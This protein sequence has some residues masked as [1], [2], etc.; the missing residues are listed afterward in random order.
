MTT[1]DET[2]TSAEFSRLT[3]LLSRQLKLFERLGALSEHQT[4]FVDTGQ[5][6]ALLALLA[7]RQR[8]VDR[9]ERI[10]RDL[11]PFRSQWDTVWHRLDASKRQTVGSLI[12]QVQQ[13]LCRILD[14]DDRDHDQLQEVRRQNR[15]EMGRGNQ[16]S[17]ARRAYGLRTE[18]VVGRFTSHA[19]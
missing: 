9:L 16:V 1:T 13:L 11:Q 19:G 8:L 14:C 4:K 5:N 7:L 18:R 12:H 15:V 2:A 10:N 17:A 6:Q 3:E